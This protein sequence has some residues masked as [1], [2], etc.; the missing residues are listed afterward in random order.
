MKDL[1]DGNAAAAIKAIAHSS[2]QENILPKKNYS[3]TN[4]IIKEE[5][6]QLED[7]RRNS[8]LD[9]SRVSHEVK[10]DKNGKKLT[11]K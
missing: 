5:E 2:K 7:S 11:E 10:D 6:R 4:Q 9:L 8:I 3:P 1:N